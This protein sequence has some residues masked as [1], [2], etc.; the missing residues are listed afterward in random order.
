MRQIVQA[1]SNAKVPV[2]VYVYPRGA[3]AASAGVF[4]TM[5]ADVAAMAPG[6][7]IGAAHPVSIG[8]G[9]ADK[10][11][12]Q[13][14]LNDM[15]AYGRSLAGER[16]RN[17]DWMEKADPPERLHPRHRGREAQGRGP[18]GRQSGRPL[19]QN[20]RP[21]SRSGRQ[22]TGPP[23]RRGGG[24][25]NS[26]RPA[27]PDIEVHRRPQ[28]RL[29]PDDDRPGGPLFR[30]RPPGS[31]APRGRRRHLPAPGLF[32]LPDPAHQF[33]RHLVDLAG[34]YFLHPGIQNHQLRPLVRGR[35]GVPAVRGDDVVSGR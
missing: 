26:R 28:H 3:R 14:L 20:Q 21:Q 31:G 15:V 18:H 24:Q 12:E 33:Y 25:G 2:V 13:K 23:H 6:T 9:K 5:A 7:N 27:L 29:Y 11:M 34:F 19:D 10:T 16:G 1:I 30:V 22:A 35:V 8:M 4:I 32:R 17:A